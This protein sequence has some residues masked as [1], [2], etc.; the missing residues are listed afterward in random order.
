MT[1]KTTKT[2]DDDIL[3]NVVVISPTS[4]SL[5]LR[6]MRRIGENRRDGQL[7]VRA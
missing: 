6:G 1:C 5:Q 7:N 2:T 4:K 3:G